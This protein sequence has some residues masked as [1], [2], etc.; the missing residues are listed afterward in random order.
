MQLKMFTMRV[1]HDASGQDT[2]LI[3][4][5]MDTVAVKK[6]ASQFVNGQPDYWSILVYYDQNG[7][8]KKQPAT[9]MTET[10]KVPELTEADL[11]DDEKQILA[12][13]RTWRKDKANEAQIAE[14][15]ILHNATLCALAKEKPRNISSLNAIKGMG[16]AKITKYGDDLM[17]IL[18]AF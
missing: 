5:F 15:M 14:F 9:S 10:T 8:D 12:A 17:A 7:H 2:Q 3:N 6:T 18:N 11:N 16:Q 4:S 13:L 1:N